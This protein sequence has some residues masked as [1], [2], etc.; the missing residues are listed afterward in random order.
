MLT[1]LLAVYGN[2]DSIV[3]RG[4]TRPFP[5]PQPGYAITDVDGFLLSRKASCNTCA[6]YPEF[7]AVHHDC[8]TIY[9]QE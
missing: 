1:W 6:L 9:I 2:E 7:I 3:Y 8:F 5:F 4:R